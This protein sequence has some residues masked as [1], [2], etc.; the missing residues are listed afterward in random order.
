MSLHRTRILGALV[1]LPAVAQVYN[2]ASISPEIRAQASRHR[3]ALDSFQVGPDGSATSHKWSGYVVTGA[4]GTVTDVKGSWTVPEVTC[5]P[6]T[7]TSSSSW[8]GIGGT[9]PLGKPTP[10]LQQIGTASDC[11]NGTPDYYAWYEF[12][13][14]E[15]VNQI[16]Y[17]IAVHHGDEISAEVSYSAATQQYTV[18]LTDETSG[19]GPPFSMSE[20][21]V[22]AQQR[23]TAEW[24][25]EAPSIDNVIQPLADFGTVDFAQGSATIN[26][27]TGPIGGFPPANVLR[28]TMTSGST[29]HG[30]PLAIPS[31]LSNDGASFSVTCVFTTFDPT[32]ADTA[33]GFGTYA[34]SINTAGAIA[35][36]YF[37]ARLVCHG[38]VRAASGAIT[39]FDAPGAAGYDHA[40]GTNAQSINAAGTITGSYFDANVEAHGL[41]RAATSPFGITPFDPP[42]AISTL[43]NS[44]NA[45]GVIAGNY[46]DAT[47]VRHGFVRAASGAITPFDPPGATE[48]WAESINTAGTIAGLYYDQSGVAHGFV[49]AATRPFVITPFDPPGATDTGAYSIN[50]AGAIAGGFSDASGGHGFVRAADGTFKTFDAPGA[51]SSFLEINSINTAGA[52]TGSYVDAN[53]VGHG[54]VRAASGAITTFD[55]PGAT[56]TLANSINAA[57]AITGYYIDAEGAGHGFLRIPLPD[58]R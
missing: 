34:Q 21:V 3:H 11:D 29:P 39:T 47:F 58:A 57:G 50:T 9:A 12:V 19:A 53:Y 2:N 18:T 13:P 23:S 16:I 5:I 41:V 10:P 42:G 6:A 55:F 44:I 17:S 56:S 31:P 37:D 7:S 22:G 24:I 46:Q 49:R 4:A 48:T 27:Q 51:G 20:A 54:F 32:G 33:P 1:V 45:A 25:A 26:G 43:P 36:S 30:G 28:E 14:Q 35:G 52:I 8:V 38:F 40:S 15:Q